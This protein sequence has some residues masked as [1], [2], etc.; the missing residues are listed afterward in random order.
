MVLTTLHFLSFYYKF[1]FQFFRLIPLFMFMNCLKPQIS[2]VVLSYNLLFHYIIYLSFYVFLDGGFP[3]FA[4]SCVK[5]YFSCTY[6]L[7][8]ILLATPPTLAFRLSWLFTEQVMRII[9]NGWI[10]VW[11]LSSFFPIEVKF[12]ECWKELHTLTR[13][14]HQKGIC[15][16]CS[17]SLDWLRSFQ[18][19]ALLHW[20]DWWEK[21]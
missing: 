15:Q 17:H 14:G 6:W 1:F 3:S 12:N 11:V 16:I 5:L 9:G 21:F 7:T 10:T 8:F 20:L 2:F 19:K 4:I 18:E 13:E